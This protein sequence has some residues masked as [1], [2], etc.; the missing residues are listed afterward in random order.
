MGRVLYTGVSGVRLDLAPDGG[1]LAEMPEAG[2]RNLVGKRSV[3]ASAV[4]GMPG[5]VP[6][7]A[8]IEPMQGELTVLVEVGAGESVEEQIA[9]FRREF[10]SRPGREGLLQIRNR[11][12]ELLSTRVRLN[13][14]IAEQSVLNSDWEEVRIPVASDK[15]VW[16]KPAKS[17]T[18]TV[19]VT[20]P[21]DTFLWPEIV[22]TGSPQVTLPSGMTV[23][24]PHT[25]VPRQLSL[26][27]WT[28]HEVTDM[29][30]AVDEARSAVTGLLSLGEGVPEGQTRT[31]VLG[32]GTRL[33]WTVQVLD[34]WR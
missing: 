14:A 13:G 29:D 7:G 34:P 23:T 15:G 32:A 2:I 8:K 16:D 3:S 24:L 5:Q 20:N 26:S 12:G 21:G 18:G 17:D 10:D 6:H 9:V 28:S 33:V 1:A 11:W 31:Y 30:G 25:P 19:T 27:P 4:I 22:W